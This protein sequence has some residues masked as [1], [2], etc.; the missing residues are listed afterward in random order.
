[1]GPTTSRI[2]LA[3]ILSLQLVLFGCSSSPATTTPGHSDIASASESP[4]PQLTL[5]ADPD[6]GRTLDALL[7][8]AEFSGS[9]WGIAVIS[10][11]DGKLVYEK[12]GD[13]L[14]T[15][16]SN[17]KVYTTAVALDLL[18]ADYRWRT[19]V[20]A[21]AEPDPSGTINGDLILYGRGSPDLVATNKA[22][23]NNS[24]EELARSL[25]N[26]GV[27]RV[28]GNVVGDESYFRGNPV[29]EGWEWNDLQWYF[30]AEASALSVNGNSV[31]VSVAP[32]TKAGEQPIVT[33]SDDDGYVQVTNN[34]A[35]V[36]RGA[37]YRI[38]INR[39]LSDNK[40]NVWGEFPAGS[41][42]YGVSLSVHHPSLWAA[43]LFAKA[44]RSQGITVDGQISSRD[45]RVPEKERLDPQ[46][47]VELASASGKTLGEIVRVT[48][49]LSVNLY[50]E[51]ILRT[52][53]HERRA[54]LFESEPRGRERGDDEAGVGIIRLW[55]ARAGIR[56]DHL[57]LHDGSG[58]SRL[59]L[60]TPVATAQLM[61]A[62]RRTNSGQVFLDSLPVAGTD[63][64]LGGRLP[65]LMGRVQ[66]K[67][68]ALT[69]DNALSGYLT[70]GNGKS[71]VFSIISN[72]HASQGNAIRLIDRLVLA[73]AGD[74]KESSPAQK[75]HAS[76]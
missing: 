9:R 17:M 50:A 76:K 34:V 42:G 24:L 37:S 3:L 15:P 63:G 40:V 72:D 54:L 75:P 39:G 52:L 51:L 13:K 57:A 35:T 49:K 25:A 36:E 69:Y 56:S 11:N 61:A 68:G 28:R 53:G 21:A 43:R 55:L 19:S 22:D 2:S 48:N 14:F 30:G 45:S 59:D 66:A 6:L 16:A 26:R 1:M 7:S 10:L 46:R 67:T 4:A 29:G 32:P 62:M 5:H 44:L 31:D 38:G 64:T 74:S 73:L 60:I 23:N 20:Y 65:S 58:L 8:S 71:L 18:G 27:K 41:R 47:M 33:T 70:T 12:N